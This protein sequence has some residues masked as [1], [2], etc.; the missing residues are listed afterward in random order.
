MKQF[1]C[2]LLSI[3]VLN[4]SSACSIQTNL[5]LLSTPTTS[6]PVDEVSNI[7]VTWESLHLKG[8]LIYSVAYFKGGSGKGGLSFA[9]RSLDLTTGDVT[10][11]YE[12]QVGAWI[13]SLAV[14]PDQKNLIVGYAPSPDN[15][16]ASTREE[17]Y[18]CLWMGLNLPNPSLHHLLTRINT[19]N[20]PGLRTGNISI[21]RILIINLL[22]QVMRS[23]GLLI[24]M[25]NWNRWSIMHT[26]REYQRMD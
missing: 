8:R 3:L 7:P 4:S 2:I 18:R 25:E 16:S 6:A 1:L 10:L 17:L 21:S 11:I 5:E 19:T 22:R 20:L 26:G 12:T 13:R 15:P 24:Q 23:C 9:I 14:S